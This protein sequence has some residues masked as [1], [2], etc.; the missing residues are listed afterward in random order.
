MARMRA[1]LV[2]FVLLLVWPGIAS[3]TPPLRVRVAILREAE[4][5]RS[6]RRY[7]ETLERQLVARK[8]GPISFGEA[9]AKERAAARA[10]LDRGATVAAPLE[11]WKAFDVV[12]ALELL[13]PSRDQ[14]SVSRGP[15]GVVAWAAQDPEPRFVERVGGVVQAFCGGVSLMLEG[16]GCEPLS[17]WLAGL[18]ALVARPVSP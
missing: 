8:L 17:S 9:S 4:L 13:P 16:G 6:E 10:R 2:L 14:A 18:I 3:A 1:S 5:L 7:L 12:I 11:E 15:G